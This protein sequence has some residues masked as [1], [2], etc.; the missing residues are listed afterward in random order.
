VTG[1]YKSKAKQMLI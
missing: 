1:Y